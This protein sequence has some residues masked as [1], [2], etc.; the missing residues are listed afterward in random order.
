M[1][2]KINKQIV[3]HS[4]SLKMSKMQFP[5]TVNIMKMDIRRINLVWLSDTSCQYV[6]DDPTLQLKWNL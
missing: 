4:V 6:C 3:V 2:K 5:T 1:W